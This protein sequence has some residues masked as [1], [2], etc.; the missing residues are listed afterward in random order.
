MKYQ[1]SKQAIV[2]QSK[3]IGN[4]TQKKTSLKTFP[5]LEFDGGMC[6]GNAKTEAAKLASIFFGKTK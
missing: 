2:N 1:E 6:R 4:G 3:T 5:G